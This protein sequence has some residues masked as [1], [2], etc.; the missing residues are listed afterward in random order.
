MEKYLDRLV[1]TNER[2]IEFG[3]LLG[4]N[5]TGLTFNIARAMI[6]ESVDKNFMGKEQKMATAKQIELGKKFNL[7]FSNLSSGIA[8]AH[9]KDIME[10]LNYKSIDEQ[11]IKPGDYVINKYDENK[12]EHI[13]S[14]IDEKGHIYFKNKYKS[15]GAGGDARYL[16]KI[17][18]P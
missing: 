8:S 2:Q 6:D 1:R 7:D 5:F 4:L 16:I 11:D 12:T 10:A 17:N 18:S 14:S 3:R 13:V 9:I 15:K